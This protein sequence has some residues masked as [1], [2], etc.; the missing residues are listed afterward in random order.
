M[1][2]GSLEFVLIGLGILANGVF[3]GS[4]IALVSS[5]ISRLTELRQRR[6]RGAAIF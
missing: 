3:A 5:R 1:D 2:S 4:E 6:V